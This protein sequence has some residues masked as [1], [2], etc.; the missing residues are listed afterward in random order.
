MSNP[1]AKVY[2]PIPVP[3]M[4]DRMTALGASADEDLEFTKK[5]LKAM[6]YGRSGKGKTVL[7]TALA[8]TIT[9]SEQTIC[10]VD[11][12]EGWV[13]LDNH[14]GL[15]D[16]VRRFRYGGFSQLEMLADAIRQ[17]LVDEK[18]KI[19]YGQFGTIILDEFS[20]MVD[21]DL[22][23]ITRHRASQDGEKDPDTP[24]WPDQ[25]TSIRRTNN[26]LAPLLKLNLNVILVAHYRE[27]KIN[28]LVTLSPAFLP[29]A[30]PKIKEPLH[31]VAY[32]DA[33][34][35]QG[36]QEAQ[37]VRSVQVHPTAAVD[38]KC[39]LPISQIR[40]APEDLVQIADAFTRRKLEEVPE[41]VKPLPDPMTDPGVEIGD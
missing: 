13:S 3:S 14:E 19:N 11:S 24:T 31:L 5:N 12:F 41:T 2:K 22:A 29:K 27:D 28:N 6:L 36:S 17:G 18:N 23:L 9:P 1:V 7:A 33:T 35:V 38:A 32:V 34:A 4:L 15:K 25:N 26:V 16:R 30:Q 21:Q 20:T 40:I 10:Y 39:R 37:Y 8:Q